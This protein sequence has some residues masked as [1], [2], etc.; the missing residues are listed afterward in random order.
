[1]RRSATLVRQHLTP[2]GAPIVFDTHKIRFSAEVFLVNRLG[3]Q[4]LLQVTQ[5][6]GDMV[7]VG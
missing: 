1:M 4:A 7:S 5:A 2:N 3:V 6:C